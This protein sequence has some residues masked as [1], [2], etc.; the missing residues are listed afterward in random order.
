MGPQILLDKSLLQSL[1]YNEILCLNKIYFTV[2]AP[3]LFIEILGDLKKHP[4]DQE[5]SMKTVAYVASKIQSR[6]SVFT[7]HYKTLMVANLLGTTIET[8]GRPVRLEGRDVVAL[9]GKKGVFFDEEPER[10]ALRRWMNSEFTEAEHVLSKRWRDSTRA[11]DLESWRKSFKGRLCATSL[12]DVKKDALSICLDPTIALENLNFLLFES[13]VPKQ[14]QL[15]IYSHWLRIG[16]PPLDQYAP[17]AFYCLLVYVTFYLGLA[18][19]MI[20]SRSTN[21]VDLEYVLYL[22]FCRAFSSLDNFHIDFVPLFIHEQQDFIPGQ[23]LKNDINR[24]TKFWNSMSNPEMEKFRL[25]NGNYPPDW[26]DSI[27]NLIWKKHMRPRS[28]LKPLK[29]SPEEENKLMEHVRPMLDAIEKLK[30]ID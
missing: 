26:S 25:E 7:A 15:S 6:S 1:S 11:I 9:D 5:R 10:E 12:A 17:Y 21:R 3:V 13:G 16:K 19:R 30:T 18:N 29:L 8:A 2:Y 4:E 20:G 24:I 28:E 23:T 22:P 14:E 27:T